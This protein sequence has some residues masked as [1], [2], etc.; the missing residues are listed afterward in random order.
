MEQK[1]KALDINLVLNEYDAQLMAAN[2]EIMILRARVKG[3]ELDKG[4]EKKET[5]TQK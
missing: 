5:K 2:R 3:L 4:Q 1:E